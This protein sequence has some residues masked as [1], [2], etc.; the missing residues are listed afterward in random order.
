MFIFSLFL[1][2]LKSRAGVRLSLTPALGL[3]IHRAEVVCF[4]YFNPISFHPASTNIYGFLINP[5]TRKYYFLT[6]CIL[7]I[8]SDEKFFYSHRFCVLYIQTKHFLCITPAAFR[9]T[10]GI[11]TMP[12]P[13]SKN[14]MIYV[15]T[16]IYH[17]YNFIISFSYS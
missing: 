10:H 11:P 5:T 8:T 4:S 1:F 17:A 12:S 14:R 6:G 16:Q 3:S 7:N 13:C 9:R 15:M 2:L